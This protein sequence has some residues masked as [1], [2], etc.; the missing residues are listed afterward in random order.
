[1]TPP[2][3]PGGNAPVET[4]HLWLPLP[5]GRRLAARLWL[6][7]SAASGTAPAP[8]ILEYLPYRKRDGTAPRDATTHPIFAAAGYACLR[9]DIAGSGDSDGLFDDEYSEQELSDGE[10]VIAWAAA[11][12]WCDGTVGMIGISWGGFNGLQLAYRRP[13]ALKAV[14]SVCSTVDRHA[15]D[16]HFMGGCLLTDNFNWGAQM[17]AYMTRPPDPALRED[18]RERWVERIE[19]YPFLA[20]DWLRRPLRDD[21]WEHGSVCEDWS[22]IEAA[23]LGIGGW[24][25]AYVNAPLALVENLRGPRAALLGPWEHKYPHISQILPADFHGE[26]IGWFDRY[27]K[28]VAS[29]PPPPPAR[30]FI[31]EHDPEAGPLSRSYGPRA[32]RWVAEPVWPSPESAPI[33]L[34]PQSDGTLGEV[35]VHERIA[36]STPLTLGQNAAYF[37][38]GM[39]VDNELAADQR[40][41]DALSVTFDSAPLERPVEIAG[42]PVFSFAFQ[43]DK[44]VAQ[45]CARLCDVAPDGASMRVSYRPLNLCH[46]AGHDR[47]EGLLPGRTYHAMIALNACAHRFRAG[48]RVR[49]ALSTSYWPVLWP[50]PDAATVTLDLADCGLV[51]PERLCLREPDPAAPGPAR[52]EAG[53]IGE[54]LAASE[55]W[56]RQEE[57]TDGTLTL[58]THDFYGRLRH[59]DHGLEVESSVDQAF[60]INPSD[61]LSARHVADWRFAL[62]R[63]AFSA[64][65]ESH[66]EMTATATDFHLTRRVHARADGADVVVK[67]WTETVPR[68]YL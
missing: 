45:L 23:V 31:T 14:V 61:P 17:T 20:A 53:P 37:C 8:C 12:P 42:R 68:G 65:I 40:E 43:V 67:E 60:V 36:I 55:G 19:T 54:V 63:D 29:T 25:D 16:I 41:D 10:A 48:H 39:R 11:Q 38:P 47:A 26:V 57:A 58:R 52:G 5:D 28:G 27:L 50:A 21:Y 7:A 3:A 34:C 30:L 62:A 24:S 66:A 44:P 4:P 56:S 13:A 33:E 2:D 35:P 15:D 9:V 59:A 32:G 64:E 46:H 22:A 1:M 51:L 18:W 6:P 49:L